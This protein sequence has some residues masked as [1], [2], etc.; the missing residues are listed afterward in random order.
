MVLG[1]LSAGF[2]NSFIPRFLQNLHT[3]FHS[4]SINLQTHQQGKR[5]PFSSAHGICGLLDIG[6]S[7]WCELISFVCLIVIA[8][9]MSSV[10]HLFM[11]LLA[12]CM[13]SLEK[14]LFRSFGPFWLGCLFF[15]YWLIWA[16]YLGI[17]P[18]SVVSFAIIFYHC[19]HCLFTLLIVSSAVKKLFRSHLLTF[20]FIS[21]TLWGGA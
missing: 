21:I 3:V 13:P 7:D 20:V 10:E 15:W 12:I 19:E 9:I 17:N 18:L 2:C 16:V 5:A 6:H 1:F 11:C 8:L 14:S 4:G